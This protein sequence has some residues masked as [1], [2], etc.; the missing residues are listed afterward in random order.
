MEKLNDPGQHDAQQVADK[1]LADCGGDEAAARLL[2]AH[3]LIVA[4]QGMSTGHLRLGANA[5]TR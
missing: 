3:Q 5:A 2:L 4:R 1:A